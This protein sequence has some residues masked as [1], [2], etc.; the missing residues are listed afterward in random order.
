MLSPR[1]DTHNGGV[2]GGS[3]TELDDEGHRLV[4][5]AL[6]QSSREQQIVRVDAIGWM[7]NRHLIEVGVGGVAVGYSVVNGMNGRFDAPEVVGLGIGGPVA[8]HGLA[9][10]VMYTVSNWRERRARAGTQ[11]WDI[12]ELALARQAIKE[13]KALVKKEGARN[14][15]WKVS[16]DEEYWAGAI[17]VGLATIGVLWGDSR[18]APEY[19]IGGA[20]V[21][22]NIHGAGRG[23]LRDFRGI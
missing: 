13:Q 18:T 4:H 23:I 19:I 22:A 6:V 14:R 21:V 16:P 9:R 8:I 2:S 12:E 17:A 7:K 5:Q 11:G 10:Y 3:Y 1:L 15:W 20:G